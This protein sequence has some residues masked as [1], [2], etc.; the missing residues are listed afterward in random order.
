MVQVLHKSFCDLKIVEFECEKVALVF[1]QRASGLVV[2][3]VAFLMYYSGSSP[4]SVIL[5]FEN[6][7]V[8][9]IQTREKN[10]VNKLRWATS[11]EQVV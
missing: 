3:S 2:K 4:T 6:G 11:N 7:W 10:K 1:Q 9:I 8:S 5:W